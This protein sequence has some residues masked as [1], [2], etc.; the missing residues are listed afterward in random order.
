MIRIRKYTIESLIDR[1]EELLERVINDQLH[2]WNLSSWSSGWKV[3]SVQYYD[4]FYLV[5]YTK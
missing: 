4:G 5:T 1:S 2:D 3:V